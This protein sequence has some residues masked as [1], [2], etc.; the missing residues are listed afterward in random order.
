MWRVA[1]ASDDEAIVLMCMALNVEDQG[2]APVQPQQVRRTQSCAKNPTAAEHW[3]V[4]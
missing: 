1:T 4:T 2:S 3:S